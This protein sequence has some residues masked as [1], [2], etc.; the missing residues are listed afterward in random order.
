MTSAQLENGSVVGRLIKTII[1]TQ[2]E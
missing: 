1:R 2:M